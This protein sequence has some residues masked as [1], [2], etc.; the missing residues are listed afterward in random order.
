MAKM[1]SNKARNTC[2]YLSAIAAELNFVASKPLRATF[3]A[4]WMIE[5]I[6]KSEHHIYLPNILPQQKLFTHAI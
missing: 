1:N 2:P 3:V 4:V 5:R 6:K